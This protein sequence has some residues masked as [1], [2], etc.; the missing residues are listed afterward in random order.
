[1]EKEKFEINKENYKGYVELYKLFYGDT[2]FDNDTSRFFKSG[3]I[4]A[5]IT[6]ISLLLPVVS[7]SLVNPVLITFIGFE[8]SNIIYYL[9]KTSNNHKR[10]LE[11]IKKKYPYINIKTERVELEKALIKNKIIID[12]HDYY[13]LSVSNY[14]KYSKCEEIKENYFEET[15]YSCY[16]TNCDIQKIELDKPKIKKLV[17]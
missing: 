7:V 11:D 4:A 9:G 6:L 1:M 10:K 13:E 16:D 8:I 12:K 3:L 17:K 5:G 14:E 15:K 2:E